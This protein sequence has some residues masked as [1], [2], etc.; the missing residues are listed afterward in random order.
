MFPS[1][2]SLIL[3]PFFDLLSPSSQI[4]SIA[5]GLLDL[6]LP[7]GASL[8][9]TALSVVVV[10][11]FHPTLFSRFDCFGSR[12][13]SKERSGRDKNERNK[14]QGLQAQLLLPHC[15]Y[16]DCTLYKK[17]KRKGERKRKKKK[18]PRL[19]PLK[20][21]PPPT[22]CVYSTTEAHSR[23]HPIRVSGR[24]QSVLSHFERT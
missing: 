23:P 6:F 21:P 1:S 19:R 5:C 15:G 17:K 18:L 22:L 14:S 7:L 4:V 9:P 13:G 10:V 2:L 8:Q 20:L 16:L 11:L 3:Y 24:V 12:N